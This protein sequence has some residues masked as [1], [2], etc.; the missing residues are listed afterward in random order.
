MNQIKTGIFI[1]KLRKDK[2]WTQLELA[3]KLCVT[4][5]AVSRWETGKGFPDVSMLEPL[6]EA[7]GVSVNEI[8]VGDFI[9]PDQFQKQA[10]V[11]IIKTLTESKEKGKKFITSALFIWGGIILI[12]SLLFLGYDTSWVAVYSWIGVLLISV[13]VFRLFYKRRI[14]AVLSAFLVLLLAFCIF[15]ARDYIYVTRY[16]MPPLYRT[17]TTT[18]FFNNEKV[19]KYETLFY[20]VYRYNA[21]TAEEWYNV[22]KK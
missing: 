20:D 5:K 18:T 7:L 3:Q 6:S 14:A 11:T 15:H 9:K 17:K 21:D 2:E 22:V 10:D 16:N 19:I 1:S 13:A 4:D 12:L 8:L